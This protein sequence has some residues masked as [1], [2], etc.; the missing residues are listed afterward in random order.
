MPTRTR[1]PPDYWLLVILF[2]LLTLGLVMVFSSSS[3][4][5]AGMVETRNDPYFFLKRQG[6]WTVVALIGMYVA[7]RID[8]EWFRKWSL[9]LVLLAVALLAAVLV[10]GVGIVVNGARR[11]IALG[12]FTFQPSEF[13][14]FALVFYLAD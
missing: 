1:K 8:L 13:A 14:K 7:M 5:S 12:S 10:P 2:T 9:P 3:V 4:T 11:W 6:M